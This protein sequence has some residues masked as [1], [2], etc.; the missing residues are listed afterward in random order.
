VS[1]QEIFRDPRSKRVV[2]VPDYV[3]NPGRYGDLPRNPAVYEKLRDSGFGLIKMPPPGTSSATLEG[4]L[5]ITVDQVEEYTNRGFRIYALSVEG[6]SEGGIS[7]RG[8][9]RELN[10]RGV[11]FP[12]TVILPRGDHSAEEIQELLGPILR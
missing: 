2:I 7:L 1:L 11:P 4:W 8:L 3:M 10:S 6:L 12:K 5:K 9:R